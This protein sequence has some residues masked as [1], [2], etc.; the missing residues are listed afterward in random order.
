MGEVLERDLA[1]A[2]VEGKEILPIPALPEE[3]TYAAEAPFAVAQ[4]RAPCV[5]G[6]YRARSVDLA[7]EMPVVPHK[8]VVNVGFSPTFEGQENPEKIVEAHLMFDDTELASPL[9][10]PDFYHEMM[11][12]QLIGFLTV[13]QTW[14][15]RI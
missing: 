3:A 5:G 8:A 2:V 14:G 12:L 11:R 15:F 6:D 7:D 9:D 1:V 10:P 4:I 13:R